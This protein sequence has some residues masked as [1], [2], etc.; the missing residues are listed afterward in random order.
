MAL[1]YG[2][3]AFCKALKKVTLPSTLK[4]IDEYTFSSCPALESI[5]IPNGV[6]E[7]KEGAFKS[8]ESLVSIE[9]PKSVTNI[10]DWLFDSCSFLESVT[11]PDSIE[12]IGYAAF[13]G[14]F[15]LKEISIPSSVTY[16]GDCA[17]SYSGLTDV[18]YD[19]TK[20][21]WNAIEIVNNT[22]EYA[23]NDLLIYATKHFS[24]GTQAT[25]TGDLDGNGTVDTNDVFEAMLYVAYRGAGMSGNLRAEQITAAD[26]DGDGSVDS[27]D[28]YYILYYVALQ[29]AGKKPTWDSVLGR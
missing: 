7:I 26:I 8:C 12:K 22:N 10:A 1:Y 28:V 2:S 27:T 23:N 13:G 18:Y 16:I 14:C 5:E 20:E 24:D 25:S 11:I 3:L 6:T 15:N 9:I 4:T 19:G 29:G 21:Q 17:F